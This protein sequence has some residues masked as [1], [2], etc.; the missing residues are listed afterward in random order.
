MISNGLETVIGKSAEIKGGIICKG[1]VRVDG[2]VEGGVSGDDVVI[3]GEQAVIKGNITG[4]HV[5]I[6]GRVTGDVTATVKL[7]ILHTGKL[8]GDIKTP[9]IAIAEGVVF[10]GTCDMEALQVET[11]KK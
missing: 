1:A 6:G 8:F 11:A 7:E 3:I 4:T 10:E 5:V 2:K 9:K